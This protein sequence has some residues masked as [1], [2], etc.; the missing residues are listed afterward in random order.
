MK[1]AITIS[2]FP[3]EPIG[4]IYTSAELKKI[5][6]ENSKALQA[7]KKKPSASSSKKHK[8]S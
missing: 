8:V 7:L 5:G 4:K 3:D 2:N 1:K 6:K